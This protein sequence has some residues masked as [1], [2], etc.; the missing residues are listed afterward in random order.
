L[1]CTV[2]VLL[3]TLWQVFVPPFVALANN[4]DFAKVIGRF[5]L[6]Q[7]GGIRDQNFIYVV[8][9]WAYNP[10]VYWNSWIFTSEVIPTGLAVFVHW[11]FQRQT[12]FDIRYM[13]AAHVLFLALALFVAMPELD[14]LP[15]RCALVTGALA[16][17]VL[18]D[19]AYV[20][21]WNTFYTDAAGMVFLVLMAA[22]A[23]RLARRPDI[24]STCLYGVASLLLVTS[25]LQHALPAVVFSLF[26]LLDGSRAKLRARR[27]I[28]FG[29]GA[30]GI[31]ALLVLAGTNPLQYRDKAMFNLI[32]YEF[33]PKSPDPH[34][35][36]REFGLE[37]RH[38]AALGMY[39]FEN[40]YPAISPPWFEDF[41]RTASFSRILLY[42]VRHPLAVARHLRAVLT[43][44]VSEIRSF[45]LAN[46][47][48][49]DGVP[50]GTLSRRFDW[51][52]S[53]SSRLYRAWPWLAPAFY[54]F[55]IAVGIACRRRF[56]IWGELI[57]TMAAFGVLE[58]LGA[59]LGDALDTGRHLLVFHLATDLL[60]I[61]V[62][63]ALCVSFRG[64]TA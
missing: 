26:L 1:L 33:A 21:Y 47:R 13:G 24:G 53:A 18:T 39:A 64:K 16:V 6:V 19:V 31:A 8:G 35:A 17:L 60:F 11:I 49:E 41:D 61:G 54:V 15:R 10:K 4:G 34:A 48:Q 7:P 57:L 56:Q 38:A 52:S 63:T 40:R 25:K 50:P 23:V 58:F 46:F 32:F 37:E 22:C 43:E 12:L 9:K 2:A 45:N 14:R 42:Y 51:W 62:V 3:I 59:S 27:R 29:F 30:A 5:C 44:N 28:A 36:L 55:A 20:C